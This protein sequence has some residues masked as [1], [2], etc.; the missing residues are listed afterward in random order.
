MNNS[1]P[2]VVDIALTQFCMQAVPS[3][4]QCLKPNANLATFSPCIE[5]VQKTRAAMATCG[6]WDVRVLECLLREHEVRRERMISDLNASA[7]E[8][9]TGEATLDLGK[10]TCAPL[11]GRRVASG[12]LQCRGCSPASDVS[13]SKVPAASSILDAW[14]KT[15]FFFLPGMPA[16]PRCCWRVMDMFRKMA[17]RKQLGSYLA[18]VAMYSTSACHEAAA[19]ILN[20]L[21]PEASCLHCQD[22]SEALLNSLLAAGAARKRKYSTNLPEESTEVDD[23]VTTCVVS[24]PVM[25]A[26]GHTGYLVFAR[27]AVSKQSTAP[28]AGV[29][30]TLHTEDAASAGPDQQAA[31]FPLENG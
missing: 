11:S 23:A 21:I 4:A 15:S 3:A 25:E 18:E 27:Q 17:S 29:L 2:G 26:R 9:H 19:L 20:K 7:A 8:H 30:P 28:A 31:A 24:R 10:S 1:W 5:Q 22:W 6:F 16:P 12:R 14:R 13:S